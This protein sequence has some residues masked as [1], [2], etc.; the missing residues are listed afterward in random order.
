MMNSKVTYVDALSFVLDSCDLPAEISEKLSALKGQ[1][2]RRNSAERKPTAKQRANA[3]ASAVIADA[4]R[5]TLSASN[6]PLTVAELIEVGNLGA[7]TQKVSAVLKGM[8]AEVVRSVDKR[9]AYYSL[10][11]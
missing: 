10:A 9:K 5:A 6:K 3:E 2:V 8:G 7:S 1:I 11:E 4:I